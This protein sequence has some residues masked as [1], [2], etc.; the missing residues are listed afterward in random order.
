MGGLSSLWC[1]IPWNGSIITGSFYE[2][3][4]FISACKRASVAF[5]GTEKQEVATK[6]AWDFK[7]GFSPGREGR[8]LCPEKGECS[9]VCRKFPLGL[10]PGID[11]EASRTAL[12]PHNHHP[13]S[14][15]PLNFSKPLSW[16]YFCLILLVSLVIKL[17]FLLNLCEFL[18]VHGRTLPK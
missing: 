1:N 10:F 18:P 7:A 3:R 8:S 5:R 6:R 14:T 16:P 11:F 4:K 17:I 12:P 13:P 15:C 2:E 9:Q